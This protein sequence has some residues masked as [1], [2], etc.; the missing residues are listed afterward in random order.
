V[1]VEIV[2]KNYSRQDAKTQ[3]I[4]SVLDVSWFSWRLCAFAGGFK[5]LNFIKKTQVRKL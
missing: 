1:N 2:L 5:V 3:R 4:S